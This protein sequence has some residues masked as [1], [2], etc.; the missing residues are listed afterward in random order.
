[1]LVTQLCLTLCNPWT[2]ALQAPLSMGFSRQEYWSG[3]PC[4]PPGDLPNPGTEPGTP[5]LQAD[6]LPSEPLGETPYSCRICA[7]KNQVRIL[8]RGGILPQSPSLSW[9]IKEFAKRALVL[10]KEVFT[11]Y[12]FLV[13]LEKLKKEKKTSSPTY[14]RIHFS[15]LS[16]I[17]LEHVHTRMMNLLISVYNENF[18]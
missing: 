14:G 7:I 6:S 10:E 2:V 1:M 13:S 9:K 15:V 12:A 11:K 5:T 17:R 16:R 4:L 8:Y 18:C 3:L